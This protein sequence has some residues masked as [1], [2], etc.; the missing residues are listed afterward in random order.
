GWTSPLPLTTNDSRLTT[1]DSDEIRPLHR[2][3]RLLRHRR[4]A[5]RPVAP[6]PADRVRAPGRRPR[7]RPRAVPGGTRGGAQ[8]GNTGGA[9]PADLPR[10]DRPATRPPPLGPR[11][12][13][14]VPY[15]GPLRSTHRTPQLG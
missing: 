12:P 5:R 9:G 11:P 13:R 15:P 8:R 10:S 2:P 3:P 1:H 4:R 7:R 14:P 6:P